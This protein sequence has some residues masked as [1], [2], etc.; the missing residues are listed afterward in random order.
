MEEA[1]QATVEVAK[2]EAPTPQAG[3]S[4]AEAVS[5]ISEW[6][7]RSLDIAQ[8][9]GLPIPWGYSITWQYRGLQLHGNDDEWDAD[10]DEER[11]ERR[12]VATRDCG[13]RAAE[14]EDTR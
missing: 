13:H 3:A 9:S 12:P 5:P 8:V 6:M 14:V 7:D 11:L 2:E 10:V 1:W 4:P